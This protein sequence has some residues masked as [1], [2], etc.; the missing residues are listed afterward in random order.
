M[1]P[2]LEDI[3][4][5]LHSMP[6]I[7]SATQELDILQRLR[8]CDDEA[9]IGGLDLLPEILS[10]IEESHSGG[11]IFEVNDSNYSLFLAAADWLERLSNQCLR[12]QHR[13]MISGVAATLRTRFK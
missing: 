11:A 5:S 4:E 9:S 12:S 3:V 8:H 7:M 6:T 13:A 1:N 10:V 2:Q